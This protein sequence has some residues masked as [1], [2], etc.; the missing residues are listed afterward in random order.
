MN[1]GE[2][3]YLLIGIFHSFAQMKKIEQEGMGLNKIILSL[4]SNRESE[5]NIRRANELLC[6]YLTSVTFSEAAYTEA[7]GLPEG[8]EFLNQVA[9]GYTQEQPEA[10]R[11]TLKQMERQ[12]GRTPE[13]K[14]QGCI[15]ID[16]D[17]L[18]WNEQVLKPADLE[19]EYV[20]SLLRTLG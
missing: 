5:A 2:C 18:Q 3:Q 6:A 14:A 16:I 20:V 13:G 12:L 17:L 19:R 7:V 1:C 9:V 8:G 4:G 11:Q 15:P 10:I